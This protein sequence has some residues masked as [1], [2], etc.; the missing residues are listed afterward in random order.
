MS[1]HLPTRNIYPTESE[2][3][4]RALGSSEVVN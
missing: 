2:G 1:R 4:N 3:D